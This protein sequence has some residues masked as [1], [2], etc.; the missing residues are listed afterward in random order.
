MMKLPIPLPSLRGM[1]GWVWPAV[2]ILGVF[3][4]LPIAIIARERATTI[5]RTRLQVIPDMDQ[6]PR[7]KPQ[8]ANPLFADGRAMRPSVAGTVAS[9]Q[10]RLDDH[11]S[12]GIVAGRWAE[13]FPLPLTPELLGRGRE[14][15]NIYCAP[16][17]GYSG[18]GDGIVNERALRLAEGT[19]TPPSNLHDAVVVGRPVGHLYNSIA[20]GIRSM[21]AYG[22]QIPERDRWAIVAYVRALQ[23]SQRTTAD[24]VP[25]ELRGTLR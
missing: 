9:G 25:A 1:P 6:Q 10:A 3:S 2:V 4:F 7:F 15:F 5:D 12:R 18:Q 20:N 8:S 21:P 17:H 24:D 23:R 16:C 19:W 22:V 11:S 13:S 14:R